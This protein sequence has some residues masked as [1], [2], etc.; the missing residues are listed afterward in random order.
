LPKPTVSGRFTVCVEAGFA[1]SVTV[2]GTFQILACA[3]APENVPELNDMPTGNTAPG[4]NDHVYGGVP[5][6]A[7]TAD[8]YGVL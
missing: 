1:E 2:T 3:G 6:V 5:P 7:D 4:P 8:E